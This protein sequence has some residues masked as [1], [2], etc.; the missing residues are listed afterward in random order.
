MYLCT[1]VSEEGGDGESSDSEE[2]S[3]FS[4]T[5]RYVS[6]VS[7]P[8]GFFVYFIIRGKGRFKTRRK[9]GFR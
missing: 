1:S 7:Y 6:L 8:E 4:Y 9:I 3:L 5:L 2:L